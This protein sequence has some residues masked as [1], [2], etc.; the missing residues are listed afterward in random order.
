MGK[1]HHTERRRI[2]ASKVEVGSE[3]KPKVFLDRLLS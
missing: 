2:A 3:V 1:A